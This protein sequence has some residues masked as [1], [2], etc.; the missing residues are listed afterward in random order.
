MRFFGPIVPLSAYKRLKPQIYRALED[1]TNCL[2]KLNI[3]ST[4][5]TKTCLLSLIGFKV[6]VLTYLWIYLMLICRPYFYFISYIFISSV[7]LFLYG[8]MS[9]SFYV[10]VY[11]YLTRY[12]RVLLQ[13]PPA[14]FF[15]LS[16]GLCRVMKTESCFVEVITHD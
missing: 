14:T 7:N 4:L 1:T 5:T 11:L 9:G 10:H 13:L 15:L 2:L 16:S 12:L 6:Y 8:R 3:S